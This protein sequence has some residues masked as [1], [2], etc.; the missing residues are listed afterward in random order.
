MSDTSDL[1][2]TEVDFERKHIQRLQDKCDELRHK[3]EEAVLAGDRLAWERDGLQQQLAA[4]QERIA[5]LE[6]E[7]ESLKEHGRRYFDLFEQF[8]VENTRLRQAIETVLADGESQHPG[9]WGPDITMVAVL[10]EA[11]KG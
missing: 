4:A 1:P 8:K 7:N 3:Y 2:C 5:A 6:A 10:R 9:G 11:L